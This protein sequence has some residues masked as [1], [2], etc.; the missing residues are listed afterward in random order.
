[1][2]SRMDPLAVVISR[3]EGVWVWDPE[4]RKYMDCLSSYSAVNQGH[5]HPRIIEALE[6]LV[7]QAVTRQL[8][9]EQP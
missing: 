2:R 8:L 7:D 1:M 6:Q 9:A 5:R 3:A 4:D